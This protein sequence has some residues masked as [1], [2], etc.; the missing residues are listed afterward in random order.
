MGRRDRLVAVSIGNQR[1]EFAYDGQGRMAS[2]R[3]LAGGFQ[4]SFRRFV[5]CANKLCEERDAAGGLTKRF[6]P[7]GMELKRVQ[8][9]AV[10]STPAIIWVPS[11][12]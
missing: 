9:R 2:I 5:W 12:N 7:Q 10:T 1:T 11:E 4:V 8:A 6:L 3:K